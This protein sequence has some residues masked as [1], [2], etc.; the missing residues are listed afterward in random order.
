MASRPAPG[1]PRD[2]QFPAVTRVTLANGLRLAVAPMPRLP[3]VTVLAVVDA[4]AERD[5]RGQEGVASLTARALTEG[6][7]T[8]DGSALTEQFEL[9][10]SGLDAGAD[11]DD[12]VVHLNVTPARIEAAM[13]LLADVLRAPLFA[14]RDIERLKAERLSD[15][16]QQQVEPR[17]LA[18][19]KFDEFLFE[20]G[21]RYRLPEGGL[22]QTVSALDSTDVRAFHSRHYVPSATTL[23]F[24][25]DITVTRA[26]ELA[27][28]IFGSWTGGAVAARVVN[29]R[30]VDGA[31]RVRIVHKP[32]APQSEL[33]VGH[34]G[35]ARPHPDYF[36]VVVM[37]ALLGG[38]FS[39]RINLNLREKN[40]FTYGAHSGFD[41]RR[42]AGPFV[43]STAVKTEVTAAATREIL[44]EI[45]ALRAE[46]VSADELSLATAYLDGVFPI[47][48]ETTS[49][50]ASAVA[51]A[52]V[53]GLEDDY[54]TTYRANVRAVT[55]A[56]VRRAAETYLHPDELLI[57]AVG[58]AESIREPMAALGVGV[59]TVHPAGDE[60]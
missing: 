42:G 20:A 46:T 1:A 21:S 56:D 36:P 24:T 33:R 40:A 23:V 38:L 27:E 16:L 8:L 32:E 2:Y 28:R 6:A 58:D 10:G 49:S 53:F 22:R 60:S 45:D 52:S 39:S 4:G 59:P 12:A 5:P 55:A 44:N 29:D 18:T 19:D 7:G 54:F 30:T 14:E 3:L 34:R 35:L 43:V 57:L 37:N 50:V 15:L 41:W 11:W 13:A 26:T 25:G 31:R 51:S 9:L 48:Y 17:G 47:R